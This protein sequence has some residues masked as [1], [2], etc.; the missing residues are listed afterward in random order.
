ML[1]MG[2]SFYDSKGCLIVWCELDECAFFLK[3]LSV[4]RSMKAS[5]AAPA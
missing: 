2:L 3:E 5:P 1:P 4:S